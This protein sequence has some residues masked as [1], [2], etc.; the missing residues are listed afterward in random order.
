MTFVPVSRCG[1]HQAGADGL[2]GDGGCRLPSMC[3]VVN[4]SWGTSVQRV[5]KPSSACWLSAVGGD[6]H[7]A[8]DDQAAV[9]AAL[10]SIMR[11]V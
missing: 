10:L 11:V 1:V 3:A 8:V 5:R 7:C 4:G 6:F 2:G 9:R